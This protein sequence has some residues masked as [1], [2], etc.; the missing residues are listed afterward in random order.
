MSE[1]RFTNR[2]VHET[3]PYLLKH[4]NN[5]VDWYPWGEEAL[6]RARDEDKPIFLSIGYSACHWCHVMERE[7]FENEEIARLLNEQFVS[8]KVDRE[9]RPDLDDIYMNA[10]QLMTGSGGWPM[11]VFLRP[12]GVPFYGGTYFPP[13]PRWGNPGFR[14]IVEAVARQYKTS[15]ERVEEV[16][17]KLVA[18]LR[19]LTR[20][21]SSAGDLNADVL[22]EAFSRIAANFDP[23]NGG[24]G[25][26][27]KFPNAMNLSVLLREYARTGSTRA[28]EMVTLTLEKMS[29]GGI[30]DQ[31]GGGFHRYSVDDHWLV[32]HFEK[33]LYDNALLAR[34]FLEAYQ[35]TGETHLMRVARET[36]DYVIREMTHSDGGFY[37]TQDADSEGEEGKFF[38][39]DQGE[40]IR[41]LGEEEGRLL[42]R[43]FDVQE[44]GNFE[45]GKSILNLPVDSDILARFLNVDADRLRE[46]ADRGKKALFEARKG[47]I[48]PFRDEKIQ[49]NWNG[50]MISGFALAYQ[51]LGDPRYLDAAQKG[52][53]FIL[54]KMRTD[55]GELLHVFK[56]G[57]ARFSAYQDDYASLVCALIDLYETTFEGRWL[58]VAIELTEAMLASFWDD[59]EGGFFFVGADHETLI[60]RSKNPHDNAL[61]SGNALGVIALLRLGS[62]LAREDFREKAER[63]L[64]LFKRYLQEAPSGFGQMLCAL[65]FFMEHPVEIAVIGSPGL[66]ETK[67]LLNVVSRSWVPSRVIAVLDPEG[68]P[69]PKHLIPF[70]L[71]KAQVDGRPT[72]YVCRNFTCSAPVTAPDDLGRLLRGGT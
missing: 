57:Q 18:G 16:S 30:Y 29:R 67:A 71:D 68:P 32:P 61:P 15:P 48:A 63:T 40:V 23:R 66:K 1:H 3:S 38:V 4:A 24:F 42:C 21:P 50:L 53:N 54:G 58:E 60:V 10:V 11:S 64:V 9:E 34:L 72:A 17:S 56:D 12:D 47:R 41:L 14:S 37:S 13:E 45:R 43:Y 5:P 70:L 51:V 22:E 27:P 26:Q 52:A 69:E 36:L 35:I 55:E 2:L 59:A 25:S 46:T 62:L 8:I 65:Y 19:R 31:L 6:A 33:M 39:W 28:M 49:T 7:S 44:G 20:L